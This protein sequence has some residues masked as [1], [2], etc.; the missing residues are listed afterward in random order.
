LREFDI[1]DLPIDLSAKQTTFNYD[2]S[3]ENK[4]QHNLLNG[5][6]KP[7]DSSAGALTPQE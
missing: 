2:P 6:H 5:F 7:S 3:L 1:K 4:L